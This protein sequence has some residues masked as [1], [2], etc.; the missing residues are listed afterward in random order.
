MA[1]PIHTA[2]GQETPAAASENQAASDNQTTAAGQQVTLSEI[3]KVLRQLEANELQTRDAAEKQLVELGPT[4]L[5]FLPEVTPN[6]SGELKVRLQRIRQ[7][8]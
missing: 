7:A 6:T 3:R 2:C 1:G 4:V 5:P 8:L